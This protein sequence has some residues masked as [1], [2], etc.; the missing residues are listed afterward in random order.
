MMLYIR[1]LL[2]IFWHKI[3]NL[4]QFFDG[5]YKTIEWQWTYVCGNSGN[6]GKFGKDGNK[7]LKW[8]HNIAKPKVISDYYFFLCS[9][10]KVVE[11]Q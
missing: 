11:D 2:F 5:E 1:L 3:K 8:I 10:I 7:K 4:F 9:K 6:T